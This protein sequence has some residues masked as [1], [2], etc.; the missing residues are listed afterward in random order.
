MWLYVGIQSVTII[1]LEYKY[2]RKPTNN[3]QVTIKYCST[4]V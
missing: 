1:T 4:L 3:K 2:T